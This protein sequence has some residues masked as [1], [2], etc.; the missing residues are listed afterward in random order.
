M[1][2]AYHLLLAFFC[3]VAPASAELIRN[4]DFSSG[5]RGWEL[6]RLQQAEARLEI[7]KGSK[8]GAYI[9]VETPVAAQARHHVQLVQ[10]RLPFEKGRTYRVSFKAR[11]EPSV[12]ITA[13]VKIDRDPW[14]NLWTQP[15]NLETGWTAYSFVFTAPRSSDIAR[16]TF[17]GLGEQAGR[18]DFTDISI[19]AE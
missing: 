8:V 18:Y 12:R 19:V 2:K 15:L 10:R 17:T 4:G 9:S 11:A 3:L 16:L 5:A 14:P 6:E 7:I 1:I 13:N